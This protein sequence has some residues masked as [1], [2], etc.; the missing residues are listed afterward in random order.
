VWGS[1]TLWANA[2]DFGDTVVW[3]M[4]AG[5]DIVWGNSDWADTVVWGMSIEDGD[6]VVWGNITGYKP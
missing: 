1:S 4:L 5:N 2:E 3:G 6:T